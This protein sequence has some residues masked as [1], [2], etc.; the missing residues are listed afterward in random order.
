MICNSPW[1]NQDFSS[2]SNALPEIEQMDS[3]QASIKAFGEYQ[4]LKKLAL[5][6][7]AYKSTSEEI[8]FL[9]RFFNKFDKLK[10]GEISLAEFKE[11]LL[12][13]YDYTEE[14]A[15]ALFEGIDIDG[16]GTCHYIEFLAATIES[17]GS[18]DEE[19]L[20]EAF[21]RIDS[22][23]SGYI[24]VRDLR[25]F[26]GDGIPDA[27]LEK[28]IDEANVSGGDHT[29]SYQEFLGLWDTRA[30]AAIKA[31]KASVGSRRVSR[32]TSLISS[33]SS[34]NL[35]EIGDHLSDISVASST[36]ELKTGSFYYMKQKEMSVRKEIAVEKEESLIEK[37]REK[38]KQL[39]M[40]TNMEELLLKKELRASVGRENEQLYLDLQ[41]SN[42][43]HLT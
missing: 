31:A 5:M 12:E 27:Y 17:H 2:N 6:V 23:D 42:E 20:A 33:T 39:R 38:M 21:D 4:T 40:S 24:T 14:E 22:D 35:S 18:I 25:E 28:V 37:D 3:I 30:D 43:N 8:G 41:A 10:D 9:R 34:D 13:N 15:E 11:A 16:T 36:D 32:Q 1:L 19:R 29:I 7:V 26:L